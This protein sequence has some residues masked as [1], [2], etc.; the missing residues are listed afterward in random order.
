MSACTNDSSVIYET[1]QTQT[2]VVFLGANNSNAH[3]ESE[4]HLAIAFIQIIAQVPRQRG[5]T[6]LCTPMCHVSKYYRD[7]NIKYT[8]NITYADKT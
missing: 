3:I 8:D 2:K 6:L 5:M 1:D 7:A 4:A